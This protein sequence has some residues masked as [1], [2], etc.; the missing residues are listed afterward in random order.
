M[1]V[2][3]LDRPVVTLR[4]MP[5]LFRKF[6]AVLAAGLG[7]FLAAVVLSACVPAHP[8]TAALVSGERISMA[9]ADEVARVLCAVNSAGSMG[10]ANFEAA[11]M[12]RQ[13]VLNLVVR[14]VVDQVAAEENIQLRAPDVENDELAAFRDLLDPEDAPVFDALIESQIRVSAVA[15]ALGAKLVPGE[16]NPEVLTQAGFEYLLGE[17]QSRNIELDPR[18]AMDAQGEPFA[19]SG[20]LSVASFQLENLSSRTP[21]ALLSCS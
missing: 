7:V 10:E 20:S 4:G 14:E 3:C 9:E 11:E 16:E 18:F 19:D 5:R 13:A 6:G 21:S 12:R 2:K 15:E 8:G 17:L 1:V